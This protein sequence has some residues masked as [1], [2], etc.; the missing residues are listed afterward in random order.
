V[1]KQP[2]EVAFK[3]AIDQRVPVGYFR[4][5]GIGATRVLGIRR[6][7]ASGYPVVGGFQIGSEFET[8]APDD[9]FGPPDEATIV[10]GHALAVLSYDE[11]GFYGPNSWG[12]GYGAGGWYAMTPSYLGWE[13]AG[14]F[15]AIKSAPLYDDLAETTLVSASAS[16]RKA[17]R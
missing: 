1:A 3:R 12:E 7:I 8:A 6:A 2:S 17:K 9:I 5:E 4:I 11:R 15:W 10:G 14:D 16:S 13:G